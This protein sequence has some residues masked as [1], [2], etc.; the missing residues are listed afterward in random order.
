MTMPR[1]DLGNQ[2]LG[3]IEAANRLSF[4]CRRFQRDPV[5]FFDTVLGL[6][7]WDR[8]QEILEA[9]HASE[10]PGELDWF[11]R[12]TRTDSTVLRWCRRWF[13][14]PGLPCDRGRRECTRT[15]T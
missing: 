1:V 15:G 5:G 12:D 13:L 8:Q 3:E 4:P 6:E 2:I 9:P 7:V 14:V 11:T 10:V